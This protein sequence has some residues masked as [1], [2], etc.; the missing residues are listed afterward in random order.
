MAPVK[1]LLIEESFVESKVDKMEKSNGKNLAPVTSIMKVTSS[2]PKSES[3]ESIE[4]KLPVNTE[5]TKKESVENTLQPSPNDSKNTQK[6]PRRESF[7]I[8]EVI[9]ELSDDSYDEQEQSTSMQTSSSSSK[10]SP[11]TSF[12]GRL[13]P[14]EKTLEHILDKALSKSSIA[15]SSV[16]ETPLDHDEEPSSFPTLAPLPRGSLTMQKVFEDAISLRSSENEEGEVENERKNLKQSTPLLRCLDDT[17]TIDEEDTESPSMYFVAA[18]SASV[19]SS[20]RRISWADEK[21]LALASQYLPRPK[22]AS[23]SNSVSKSS[24]AM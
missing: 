5:S 22:S 8:P 4:L 15:G 14:R 10:N 2:E 6:Y 12:S 1:S 3:L 13:F 20:S 23:P 18:D 21:G 7:S 24:L 17:S 11:S 16:D 19:H 9:T